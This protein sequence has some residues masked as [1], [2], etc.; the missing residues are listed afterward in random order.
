M[1]IGPFG[2]LELLMLLGTLV[3]T[4]LFLRVLIYLCTV[5]FL[6]ILGHKWE[7]MENYRVCGKRHFL[8][9]ER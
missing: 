1:Q 8:G 3:L 4:V 6:C 5:P 9:I 7:E 2:L